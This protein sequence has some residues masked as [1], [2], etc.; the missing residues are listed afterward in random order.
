MKNIHF[1]SGLPRAGTTLLSSILKQN[2]KFDSSISGP[3]ARFTRAIIEESQSQGG[4]RFQCPPE[5]RKDLIHSVF[6]NYYKDSYKFFFGEMFSIL[7]VW[8]IFIVSALLST[9]GWFILLY[10]PII[11]CSN[12]L[13]RKI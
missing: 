12:Y 13:K 10:L 3:L 5:K 8:A 11:A 2:P 4:Y 7:D 9:S 1:I 6:D